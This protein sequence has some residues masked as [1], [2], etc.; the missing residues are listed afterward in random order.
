MESHPPWMADKLSHLKC[1]DQS[2][3]WSWFFLPTIMDQ[4]KCHFVHHF[5]VHC[6]A[7]SP[8]SLLDSSKYPPI[9]N[10]CL[11]KEIKIL[12]QYFFLQNG[13]RHHPEILPVATTH[14]PLVLCD[15]VINRYLL[16]PSHFYG[17][18]KPKH[19]IAKNPCSSLCVLLPCTS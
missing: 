13:R 1:F 8:C 10:A 4:G 19:I 17:W 18:W 16:A 9:T 12:A 7:V 6:A 15:E 5:Y 3:I 2:Q 14:F 11:F